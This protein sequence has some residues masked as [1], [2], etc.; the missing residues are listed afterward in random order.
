[1]VDFDTIVFGRTFKNYFGQ[2]VGIEKNHYNS[3]VSLHETPTKNDL[4]EKSFNADK[5][6]KDHMAIFNMQF[7][8]K[9]GISPSYFTVFSPSSIFCL[10]QGF[11]DVVDFPRRWHNISI[12]FLL[13]FLHLQAILHLFATFSHVLCFLLALRV[14]S[15]FFH[16]FFVP[17]RSA[18][19]N[20]LV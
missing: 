15:F 7:C 16:A 20:V 17:A 13:M 2:F 8:C 3:C 9:T 18:I 6:K 1:M 12:I 4:F 19:L 5:C 10:W 11:A 14:F